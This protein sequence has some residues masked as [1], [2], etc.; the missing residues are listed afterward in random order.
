MYLYYSTYTND[1]PNG[2]QVPPFEHGWLAQILTWH[3]CML[4]PW[5]GLSFQ[6]GLKVKLRIGE[7]M[8]I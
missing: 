8:Q 6:V 1:A 7:I 4:R 5:T 3:W 2:I